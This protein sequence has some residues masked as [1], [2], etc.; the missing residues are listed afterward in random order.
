MQ[1]H[2]APQQSPEQLRRSNKRKLVWG[3]I[4]IVGPTAL[5]VIGLI[6][7]AVVNFVFASS[8]ESDTS[9]LKTFINILLFLIGTASVATMLPGLVVGIILLAT[10]KRI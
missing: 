7:Y 10:R 4:C 3:V 8:M 2:T 6:L 5:L 9:P 1:P